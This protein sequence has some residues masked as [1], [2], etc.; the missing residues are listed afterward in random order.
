MG[1]PQPDQGAA[2][3]P[4]VLSPSCLVLPHERDARAYIGACRGE[5]TGNL[6][7]PPAI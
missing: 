3:S 1:H 4:V 7:F 5:A 2:S 6:L